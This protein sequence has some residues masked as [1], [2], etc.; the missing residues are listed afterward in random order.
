MPGI[1]LGFGDTRM[2]II[3]FLLSKGLRGYENRHVNVWE[4]VSC[5]IEVCAKT[6]D[7]KAL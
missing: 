5:I 6:I 2:N 7:E 1:L 3:K 4:V